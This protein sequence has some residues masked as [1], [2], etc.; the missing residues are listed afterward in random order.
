MKNFMLLVLCAA[1]IF[2]VSERC[3]AQQNSTSHHFLVGARPFAD[4]LFRREQVK[5]NSLL[6]TSLK[7]RRTFS[8]DGTAKITLIK[9]LDQKTNGNGAYVS[10]INGGPGQTFVTLEFKSQKGHGI[11]FVVE[12]Y[13]KY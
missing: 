13:A 6:W 2:A 10:L 11:D 12:L 4:K 3:A 9:A 1:V 5:V 8:T 7:E